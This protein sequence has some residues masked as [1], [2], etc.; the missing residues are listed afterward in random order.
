MNDVLF[1]TQGSSDRLPSRRLRVIKILPFLCGMSFDLDVA[2]TNFFL[3]LLLLPKILKSR[4]VFIQKELVPISFLLFLKLLRK[5]IIFDFDD[6]IHLRQTSFGNFRTSRKRLRRFR[7][8]SKFSDLIIA[9]NE[10]LEKVA[11]H[12][13]A[14]QIV[15]IPTGVELPILS[16]NGRNSANDPITLG[17]I[18]T[19]VNLAFLECWE[20]IFE[21]LEMEGV[22]FNLK[23]M[24]SHK[25]NFL[26]FNKYEFYQW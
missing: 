8:I 20:P 14:N 15:V 23:I 5:K 4:K 19:R 12:N 26:N 10:H 1:L 11:A 3:S 24:S 7:N 17:W 9:G 18:G 13:G 25:P 21:R 22:Q 6:A 2:P 16:T